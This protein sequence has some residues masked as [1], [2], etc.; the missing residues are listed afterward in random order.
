MPLL[1]LQ[2]LLAAPQLVAEALFVEAVLAV[3]RA[4]DVVALTAPQA[5]ELEA[6]AF[7]WILH[8]EK[9]VDQRYPPLHRLRDRVVAACSR[10]LG[11]LCPV[12]LDAITD[13]FL[14]EVG[15][16]IK[17][18]AGSPSR[19]ELLQL[20]A[21]LGW[22]RLHADTPAQL[23][24]ATNFLER[25]H[26]LKHVAPDKKSRLQQAITDMLTS[27]LAPLA[28]EGDPRCARA[29][30]EQGRARTFVV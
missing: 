15:A 11:A 19:Q 27:V 23:R 12:A 25:A 22:L 5:R 28:D 7:D 4:D 2:P 20:C 21:G 13:R 14:A 29:R 10:L 1:L 6:L 8:A 17:A 9:Y 3:L 30:E 24:A 18:E 26:P 16:R